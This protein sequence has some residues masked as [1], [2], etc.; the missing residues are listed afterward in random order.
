MG[1]E[2]RIGYYRLTLEDFVI[3]S[4]EGQGTQQKEPQNGDWVE[5]VGKAVW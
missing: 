5:K 1:C 3:E 4:K 2:K